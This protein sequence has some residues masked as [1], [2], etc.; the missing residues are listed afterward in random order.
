MKTI[1]Y[2]LVLA[3]L[4]FGALPAAAQC[5]FT[6]SDPNPCADEAVTL[7]VT[8][9]MGNVDYGWDLDGDGLIDQNGAQISYNFPLEFAETTYNISL[10]ENG[11]SCTTQ[12][13]TVLASPDPALGI[14]P[15]IVSLNGTSIQACNGDNSI[16]LEIF[17]AS[18][19]F[20]ENAGYTINWGDGSPT[21]T[22]DNSTFSNTSTI[23][24][25][26]S[27]LGYYT[28]FLTATH[29]N[30]CAYTTTYT[31]Y[32]GGNPSVGLVI[33]GN[34]VGLCAP[35]T[36]EFPIT[37]TSNNPP[38]TVYTVSINGDTV[39]TYTQ[40]NLPPSF[41]Y[42]FTEGSCNSETSTGNYMHAFDVRIVAS[43]PCNS[44]TATIEPIEVSEP[45]TP[46]FVIIPPPGNCPGEVFEFENAS[47]VTEVISGNPS[48]C[49]DNLNPI[50]TISGTP[51]TDWEIVSG[52]L[53]GSN[54]VQITFLQPGVYTID[55]VLIS[56][57]CGEFTF[58]Q[59]VTISDPPTVDA[60]AVLVNVGD[61]CVPVTVPFNTQST[62]V[63]HYNWGIDPPTGWAFDGGSDS[64]S[65]SPSITFTEGGTYDITL[66]AGND[67]QEISW[68]TTI[69]LNGPPNLALDPLPDVCYETTLAFSSNNISYDEN[70]APIQTYLWSFPGSS[71][72]SDTVAYPTAI[73]YDQP[74][75]YVVS[76]DVTNGCGTTSVTDTFEVQV[77][78]NLVLPGDFEVCA[79]EET[80]PLTAQPNGGQWSGTGIQSNGNFH[81]EMVGAGTFQ[82]TYSY[83]VGAC[84]VE[85]AL[86]ATVHPIPDVDAGPDQLVCL[87]DPA[88]VLNA[89]PSGGQ[90]LSPGGIASGGTFDPQDSGL[91][92][93]DLV[94]YVE[95]GNGCANLDS[96]HI[97]VVGLPDLMVP[98]T[99]Y[100]YAEGLVTLPTPEPTGGQFDGPGVIGNQLFDPMLSNGP[101]NNTLTYSYT[102]NNGCSNEI[103]LN[104]QLDAPPLVQAGPDQSLCMEAGAIT[105]SGFSPLGGT[106]AGPGILDPQTGIFEPAVAGGGNHNLQYEYGDGNCLVRDTIQVQVIELV[107]TSAGSPA[108]VCLNQDPLLLTGG[109]PL[110]GSWS[111]E[112]IVNGNTG[113]FDP[114]SL[115]PGT[116]ALTY[117][118][119]D[120]DSGCTDSDSKDMTVHDLP[121]AAFEI[122]EI[123]CIQ[124]A[125]APV[126]QSIDA[127]SYQWDFGDGSVSQAAWP[128]HQFS[129]T[130]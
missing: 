53:F 2:T 67:C 90:W 35:A 26:Y 11:D 130:V 127:T 38:G 27:G 117:T 118:I 65:A 120:A 36:L 19:T 121:T 3:G 116:Y 89:L 77:P 110:G 96:L 91:G 114:S 32:N 39:A 34:T 99:S 37:N 82:L 6:V 48:S 7:T 125:L 72:I 46:E 124:N 115:A 107:G 52:S 59:T 70:G 20:S 49:V 87:N 12:P 78:E 43:N 21:E 22:F 54:N 122:P 105:L 58:S 31:F 111:G 68:D 123:N 45:P 66:L 106:W 40:D 92:D 102:D 29:Q 97:A 41:I 62:G 73:V 74:G 4:L 55:M 16:D 63:M 126:N 9:P 24:H 98:D 14:P 80:V 42:T 81:P 51:G 18:A 84:L 30:G 71:V 23:S 83:G 103:A 100:C 101:G 61:G 69:T 15:G 57:A 104:I 113:L 8:N 44:S 5:S 93:F 1:I 47:E 60:D 56:F 64:T 112:G 17:N 95:D 28:I 109:S 108:Q 119:Y 85:E 50:W 79:N 75:D 129:G 25:T 10:F 88:L 33:P 86:T 94:Y 128:N 13:I 76:L